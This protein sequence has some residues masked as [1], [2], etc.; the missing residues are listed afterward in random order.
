MVPL[1]NPSLINQQ[2]E[3]VQVLRK[4]SNSSPEQVTGSGSL[5]VDNLSKLFS[6]NA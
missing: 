2:S 1:I 3:R 5:L 6:K 4:A